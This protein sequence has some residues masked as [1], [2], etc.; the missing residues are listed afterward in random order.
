VALKDLSSLQQFAR[1][2]DLGAGYPVQEHITLYSPDDDIPGA[3][4]YL[5]KS[6]S[7]SLVI[8]MF[9]FDDYSLAEIIKQKMADP[10]I[11]VQ[12]SLDNTQAAGKHEAELLKLMDYPS[13][14]VS[15]GR[16]EAHAIQHLKTFVVDGLDVAGGSTNWSESGETKQDNELTVTRHPVVA[17]RAR[18]KLDLV[19]SAQLAQMAKKRA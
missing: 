11:Y 14:S 2:K 12:M 3:L 15:I 18:T 5:L 6:V 4:A 10:K 17:H 7:S 19:H 8:A 13:N 1:G 16:S 9:G